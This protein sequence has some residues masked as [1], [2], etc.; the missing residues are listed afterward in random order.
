[1]VLETKET[2]L[3]CPT[4]AWYFLISAVREN[5]CNVCYGIFHEQLDRFEQS[6]WTSTILEKSAPAGKIIGLRLE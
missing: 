6:A 1:M 2:E 3:S 4:A 5:C